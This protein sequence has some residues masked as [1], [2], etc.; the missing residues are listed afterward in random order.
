MT[1]DDD[2]NEML[3]RSPEELELFTQMDREREQHEQDEWVAN[4]GT[5]FTRCV[6]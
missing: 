1:A 3:A 6:F 2:L 5:P 4:H